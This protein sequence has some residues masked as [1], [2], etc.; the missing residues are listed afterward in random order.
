MLI[1]FDP[2]REVDRFADEVWG[3]RPQRGSSMPIDLQ[4]SGD[5]FV[6]L[7]DLPGVSPESIEITADKHVLT[8]KAER[9][10]TRIE[11]TET[12]LTER[13]TGTFTR[14]LRLG[15]GVDYERVTA[16]YEDGVLRVTIPV[17]EQAKPH[18]V[19][20]SVTPAPTAIDSG[21]DA[22]TETVEVEKVA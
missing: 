19:Q 18:R 11:G 3:K 13:R 10:S 22:Q 4:R 5:E 17:A 8:V 14:Q 20:V 9:T 21:S 7:F 2:F 1:R 12:L 16:N 6:A 15:V